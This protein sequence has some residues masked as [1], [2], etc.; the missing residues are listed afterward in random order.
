[1]FIDRKDGGIQLG[2]ALEKYKDTNALVLGIP[3]GGVE[4]A[5]YVAKHINGELSVLIAKK[6]GH[7]FNPELAIGAMAEDGSIYLNALAGSYLNA[8]FFEDA[9]NEKLDEINRRIQ[10]FRNG[11]PLPPMNG[12]TVILVDD[13]IATGATIFAAIKLCRNKNAGHIVVATPIGSTDTELEISKLADEVV[14]LEKPAYYTAVSQGY[15]VFFDL[16]DEEAGKFLE[17]R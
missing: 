17:G 1:M 7:P 12:R 14:I 9:K 11:N 2:K 5:Y 8:D 4:T 16:T 13:G 15:H 6:L 3:R 10:K